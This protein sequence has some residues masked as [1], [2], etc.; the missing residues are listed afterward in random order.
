M[1]KHRY[2][3]G[4]GYHSNVDERGDA[5]P[6]LFD[7][8]M[9]NTLEYANPLAIYSID[10]GDGRKPYSSG[11]AG[12]T[13]L[14]WMHWIPLHGNLSHCGDLLSGAK[15]YHFSGIV[16]SI[17]TLAMIA[18][19]NEADFIY[20]EQDV[21]AFG[22]YVDEMYAAMGDKGCVFG[23][24]KLMSTAL[25]LM[26]MRHSAIPEIVKMYM[27]TARENVGT[28]MCEGKFHRMQ[29]QRPDIFC[30]Y[31]FGVDR[32]RPFDVKAPI[33]YG[34]KFTPAELLQIRDAGL[35]EFDPQDM[36][37]VSNTFSNA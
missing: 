33:W 25:S 31:G 36:P 12:K 34:Q 8:W 10:S 21:L 22:P 15:P 3:I 28:E 5:M 35:I 26:L 1:S 29:E 18:Y 23:S 19:M 37:K 30:R 16:I 6:W 24:S 20:K 9:Q 17:F 2:I 14:H 32:D 7:L 13:P 27:G 4:T 11:L